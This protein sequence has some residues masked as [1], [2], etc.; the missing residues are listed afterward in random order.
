MI[1]D[2]VIDMY[3]SEDEEMKELARSIFMES[4]KQPSVNIDINGFPS[5]L[6]FPVGL[7]QGTLMKYLMFHINLIIKLL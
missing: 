5:I 6:Y 2:K 1:N 3:L 4:I 7:T